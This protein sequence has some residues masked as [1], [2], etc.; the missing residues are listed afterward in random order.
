MA[1]GREGVAPAIYER[2][3]RLAQQRFQDCSWAQRQAGRG[4]PPAPQP[5]R[6]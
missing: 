1:Q 5:G 2:L 6:A 3:A 4:F